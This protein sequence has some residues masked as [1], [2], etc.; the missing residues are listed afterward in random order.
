MNSSKKPFDIWKR[1]LAILIACVMMFSNVSNT[2]WA[3]EDNDIVMTEDQSSEETE[4]D[5]DAA[6]EEAEKSTEE[7]GELPVIDEEAPQ[8]TSEEE[9]TATS[10]E[11]D[12]IPEDEAPVSYKFLFL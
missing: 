2:V 9:Q 1:L 12:E 5:A 11:E 4:Q 7:E 6:P 3:L 10:S 8:E